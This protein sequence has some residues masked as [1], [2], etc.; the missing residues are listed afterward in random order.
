[1]WPQLLRNDVLTDQVRLEAQKTNS[2]LPLT[3][4]K[5]PEA[6][7]SRTA[8]VSRHLFSLKSLAVMQALNLVTS[9]SQNC[10]RMAC[11]GEPSSSLGK[12]RFK[13]C[14]D[15]RWRICTYKMILSSTRVDF[16]LVPPNMWTM[17]SIGIVSFEL[18]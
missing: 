1:M 4:L 8:L 12:L 16:F 6:H 18:L 5:A 11:L 7:L 17:F 10:A 14:Q 15:M 2:G 13:S 9:A 3:F